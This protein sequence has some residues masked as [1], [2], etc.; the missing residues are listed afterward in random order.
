MP[1]LANDRHELYALMR[2]KGM[3]PQAAAQAAGFVAGSSIYAEL[4]KDPEV[5]ARAQELLD[6]NNLKREQ[7]RTAATEAAKVVGQVSGLSKA[8][9]LQKL[10]EN[11][12]MAAQDGDYKESNAALKLIGDEFGM[13][14]GASSEGTEGQNGERTYDLDAM[15]ALLVKG[16]ATIPVAPPKVDPSAAFDLIAGN[17]AAA[18]RARESRA[19]SDGEESDAVFSEDADIDAVM[20]GSWSGP[21]PDDYLEAENSHQEA[22]ESPDRPEPP[23]DPVP[24]AGEPSEPEGT[25]EQIDPK[26][27]PEA[28]MARIQAAG[29]SPTSSDDRPKRRSSR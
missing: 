25:W 8:W 5:Q 16:T 18:R 6:E 12:Q 26:T 9:V 29:Q 27:S 23:A 13:F 24:A 2:A 7:M 28:I 11:A 17:G 21:S 19:F 4:E 20:D 15:S 14:S 10:A 1:R 3:K 22:P